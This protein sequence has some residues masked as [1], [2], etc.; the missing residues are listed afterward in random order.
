[1]ASIC[2]NRHDIHTQLMRKRRFP[3]CLLSDLAQAFSD[4]F[5]ANPRRVHSWATYYN[6]AEITQ[7]SLDFVKF[8]ANICEQTTN[9]FSLI[10]VLFWLLTF[11]S[12][13]CLKLGVRL[14]HEPLRYFS[15][16]CQSVLNLFSFST[17]KAVI[18]VLIML[19][20]ADVNIWVS[21]IFW[22][23][24]SRNVCAKTFYCQAMEQFR[25]FHQ[26]MQCY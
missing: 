15:T 10:K 24:K 17:T 9:F 25:T 11:F 23:D 4:V 2:L 6:V 12:K 3:C 14:I 22:S 5:S 8:I 18:A 16:H 7:C 19:W 21:G 13:S 20:R 26:M 1:M